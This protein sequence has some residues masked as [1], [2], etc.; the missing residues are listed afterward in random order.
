MDKSAKSRASIRATCKV[1]D[2]DDEPFLK[3]AVHRQVRIAIP[4]SAAY[5]SES[6]LIIGSISERS[7]S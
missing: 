4:F 7:G 6:A 5:R 1:A 3:C 2:R